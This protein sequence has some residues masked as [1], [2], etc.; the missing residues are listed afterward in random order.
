M[1]FI[2]F[3]CWINQ[4]VMKHW[5]GGGGWAVNLSL[6]RINIQIYLHFWYDVISFVTRLILTNCRCQL[7][8]LYSGSRFKLLWSVETGV[9]NDEFSSCIA[10][11][12]RLPLFFSVS[13]KVDHKQLASI[14]AWK[15]ESDFMTDPVGLHFKIFW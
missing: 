3:S 6:Y 14:T 13:Q 5:A 12:R 8:C 11:I 9:D 4:R 15:L 10:D 1:W 7:F 2:Y